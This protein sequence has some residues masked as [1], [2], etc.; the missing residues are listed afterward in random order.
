[1]P[2]FQVTPLASNH[3]AVDDAVQAGFDAKDRHQLP[4]LAGWLVRHDGTTVEVS[5][6]LEITGQPKGERSPVGATLVIL[7]GSYFGRGPSDLWEWLKT[8]FESES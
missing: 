2:I 7:V 6:H 8:R 1:M 5:S 3:Q 4:N